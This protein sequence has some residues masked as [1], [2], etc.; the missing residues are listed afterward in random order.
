[1]V[2]AVA[3]LTSPACVTWAGH[4]TCPCPRLP[5]DPLPPA[6]PEIVAATS[7]ATA[8]SGGLA[9][10]MSARVSCPPPELPR[11]GLKGA[12]LGLQFLFLYVGFSVSSPSSGSSC[13]IACS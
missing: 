12:S 4:L 3:P 5:R 13:P 9:S 2:C 8:A 7:T 6:V 1:M 10:A 11:T